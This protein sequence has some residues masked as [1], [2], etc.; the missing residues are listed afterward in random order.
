[1]T[2]LDPV[3]AAGQI[4]DD[5]AEATADPFTVGSVSTVL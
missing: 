1:M 5:G 4:G 2:D 3:A